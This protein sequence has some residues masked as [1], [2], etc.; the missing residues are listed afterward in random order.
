MNTDIE[1]RRQSRYLV[2]DDVMASVHNGE[3]IVG[4]AR[5]VSIGG[6]SFEHLELTDEGKAYQ[7]SAGWRLY[8]LIND[9]RLYEVPCRV[10]YDISLSPS[11]ESSISS[12]LQTKRC[13][14]QFQ[15]LSDNQK[16]LL[17]SFLEEHTTRAEK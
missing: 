6:L 12:S 16:I 4:K 2:K 9:F 10:V 13:G 8:L 3:R 17:E 14:V 7:E 15:T 1:R 5:D 11:T